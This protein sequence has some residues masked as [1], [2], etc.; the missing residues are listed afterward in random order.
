M[1]CPCMLNKKRAKKVRGNGPRIVPN[2]LRMFQPK[3][4]NKSLL[5]LLSVRRV[6]RVHTK[7]PNKHHK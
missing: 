1:V 3:N 5:Q 7:V 4:A 2:L 6:P